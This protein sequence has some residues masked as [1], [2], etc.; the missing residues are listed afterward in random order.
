[1]LVFEYLELLG[2]IAL[3]FAKGRDFHNEQR[4]DHDQ[5]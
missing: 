5:R 4:G 3:H 2:D 1:V